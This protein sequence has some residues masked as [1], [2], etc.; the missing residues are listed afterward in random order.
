MDTLLLIALTIWALYYLYKQI[1][2]SGGCDCDGKG[3]CKSDDKK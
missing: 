1:F 2:V 3:C